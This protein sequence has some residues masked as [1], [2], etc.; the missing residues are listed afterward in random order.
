MEDKNLVIVTA[1]GVSI[2][3]FNDEQEKTDSLVK[4]GVDGW[5]KAYN[6]YLSKWGELKAKVMACVFFARFMKSS[7]FKVFV[8]LKN[9][10]FKTLY[11]LDFD[12]QEFEIKQFDEKGNA[13]TE[14][15]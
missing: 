1:N 6:D 4:A 5:K 3:F 12:K 8:S 15:F 9:I 11:S 7:G 14:N 10:H 13:K 2:S